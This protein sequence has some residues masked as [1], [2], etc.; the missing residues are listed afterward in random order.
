MK[1]GDIMN[2]RLFLKTLG[3]IGMSSNTLLADSFMSASLDSFSNNKTILS[4]EDLITS[5]QILT[6]LNKVI[7]YVGHGN[8]NYI[9]Y[10]YVNNI[11]NKKNLS[12]TKK[13]KDFIDFLFYLK[14][15]SIN[16]YGR[17]T[18]SSITNKINKRDLEYIKHAGHFVRKGESLKLYKEIENEIGKEHIILTSGI[19]NVPKQLHLFLSKLI[20]VNG[21]LATTA[22]SIA[23][24]GYSYHSINDFDVGKVDF[25]LKNFSEAFVH[26][27]ECKQLMNLGYVN[28]RYSKNN[29]FGVRFE[30]W[31][32]KVS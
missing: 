21:N 13:E 26:T 2:K 22:H 28:I 27:N 8:F 9:S 3:I 30:P 25:G 7:Y 4:N 5:K 6:K 31:H 17:R 12:F 23:P 14:P 11:L 18:V 24:P 1:S 16:F 10:D 15:A 19:R 29:L 32:I 20:S